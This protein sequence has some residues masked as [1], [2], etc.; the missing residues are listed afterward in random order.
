MELD[1]V[2]ATHSDFIA[3]RFCSPQCPEGELHHCSPADRTRHLAQ[4]P[5]SRAQ[6][7]SAL[8]SARSALR[9][10]SQLG[11]DER[12]SY[13]HAYQQ[14]LIRNQEELAATIAWEV[15]KPLWEAKTEVAAMVQKVDLCLGPGATYTATT[16]IDSLPGE[17]RYRPL[18]LVAVIG[19][20]NFPGH[21]PNG[22]VVPALFTGNCVL[23]KP[24]E[25]TPLTGRLMARCYEEAKLPKGV[26]NLVQGDSTV[27][28]HLT[29]HPNLDGILF[30]GS[31]RVG[32]Q[33]L[34]ANV[35]K[36]DR[37]VALELGGKNAAVALDD[38]DVERTARMIVQSAF[39]TSGQRCTC[40]SRLIVTRGVAD[41]L[42]DTIV[43]LAAKLRVGHPMDESVFMGPVINDATA[44]RLAN[45]VK[46]ARAGG[47][48]TLLAG[49]SIPQPPAPGSYLA[50]SIHRIDD[51]NAPPV[52][53]YTDEELFAPDLAIQ[54]VDDAQAAC[55]L[56]NR[57]QYGLSASVFC[58]TRAQFET[59][60]QE[61]RVGVVHW[62]RPGA[63][64]SG[65]L[66]FGGVKSSGNHRS[67]G[68]LTG[69]T[70]TYPQAVLL[71]N[72]LPLPRLPGFDS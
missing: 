28:A 38:C 21:L 62:N 49:G 45:A 53:G 67:A 4:I 68:I 71:D 39:I 63:G 32:Q 65:R 70:C 50:P 46:K 60:A 15:G 43:A 30:T 16:T 11:S 7:D 61:L 55:T 44:L 10:W 34:T 33:I 13:L 41:V 59:I 27:G 8:D 47:Y 57:S 19:P 14:A 25:L 48:A 26:F 37:I 18:G 31:A 54:V 5:F 52:P 51:R 66:P 12:A 40:T 23:F 42:C 1:S 35:H 56:T 64:A 29:T 20:Y 22:Q 24:S 3:G 17:I 58:A 72:A 2:P 36:L 9:A 69:L 6:V